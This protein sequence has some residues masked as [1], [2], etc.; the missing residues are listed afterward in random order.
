MILHT[1]GPPSSRHLWPSPLGRLSLQAG[2]GIQGQTR[3]TKC[4]YNQRIWWGKL[5]M[6]FW[7]TG[8]AMNRISTN[9]GVI[10]SPVKYLSF[11]SNFALDL[12]ILWGP[13]QEGGRIGSMFRSYL[14]ESMGGFKGTSAAKIGCY[15]QSLSHICIY[16]N[17]YI[18]THTLTHTDI[19]IYIYIDYIE[20]PCLFFHH[21]TM[22]CEP[23]VE[24]P[25]DLS[26]S[27]WPPGRLIPRPLNVVKCHMECVT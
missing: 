20:D 21:L 3:S 25:A 12:W 13:R 8:A 19:Y 27:L 15:S 16:F 18:R 4:W 11:L 17:I 26:S 5:T 23:R 10:Q 14:L 7:V 24:P 9:W 22:R 6:F 1:Q 2:P